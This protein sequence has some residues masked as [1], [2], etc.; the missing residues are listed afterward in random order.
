MRAMK[1]AGLSR[2]EALG[3][4]GGREEIEIADLRAFDAHDTEERPGRH[5]ETAR[6]ARRHE[7]LLDLLPSRP[8][9]A[10]GSD[11]RLA[12]IVDG[13]ADDRCDGLTL[14]AVLRRWVFAC[15]K[16]H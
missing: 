1:R 3:R 9:L 7:H 2:I 10:I 6:I 11:I 14:I 12:E 15:L 13:V 16:L 4:I 5:Q 8:D